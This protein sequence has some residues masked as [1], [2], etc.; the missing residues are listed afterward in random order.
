MNFATI[1]D[2]SSEYDIDKMD[3]HNFR[4]QQQGSVPNYRLHSN[5][6]NAIEN[7]F[8]FKMRQK[9]IQQDVA[10]F[11][12]ERTSARYPN[13][14]LVYSI[15]DELCRFQDLYHAVQVKAEASAPHALE[16]TSADFFST[17][18]NVPTITQE[19]LTECKRINQY[20]SVHHMCFC[21]CNTELMPF[22]Q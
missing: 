5:I 6:K 8:L 17:R 22:A 15:M 7:V 9:R 11:N 4:D 14:R 19:E 16:L 10:Q 20:C 21:Y 13:T 2:S 12:Q 18:Q 3:V 1:S